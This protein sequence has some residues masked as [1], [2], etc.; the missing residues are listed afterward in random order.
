MGW[1]YIGEG[2]YLPGVPARD[3]SDEEAKERGLEETLKA[4]TIY[5]RVPDRRDKPEGGED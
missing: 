4:S 1:K 3:I 2:A 5:R